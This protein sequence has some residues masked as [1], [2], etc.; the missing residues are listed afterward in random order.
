MK[1]SNKFGLKFHHLGLAV[2]KPEDALRLLTG[3]GYTIGITVRDHLQNVNLALCTR[4]GMPAIEIIYAAET[5]GPLAEILK[6]NASMI[7]HI[8]Y[9]SKNLERSLHAMESEGNRVLLISPPKPAA[10]FG[11]RHVSF[12]LVS[13]FGMIEILET[14]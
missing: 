4:R 7:Y 3:L 6:S 13:G 8:C 12:H 2:K 1:T 5:P 14:A 11:G 9:E 10:L